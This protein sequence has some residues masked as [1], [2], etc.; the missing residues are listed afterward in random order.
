MTW[1][2]IGASGQF[3]TINTGGG[4]AHVDYEIARGDASG[5]IDSLLV[6]GLQGRPVSPL[7]P[8]SGNV[9][10]WEGINWKPTNVAALITGILPHDLLS[11][12]HSDSIP[13]SPVAGDIISATSG[14]PSLWGRFPIGAPN[15]SLS[16]NDLNQLEW[17]DPN[18]VPPLIVTSGTTVSLADEN[19]R[20]VIVKTI[21]SPTTVNLPTGPILGQE[22]MIKDG[23]GD[24]G[25]P[26]FNVIDIVPASGTTIDGFGTVRIRT[27]Y[28]AY[29]L[30]WNGT[31]WN[32]I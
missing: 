23:K 20:V 1:G 31:E 29:T 10:T 4:I 9:L 13:A 22:V 30:M 21:G 26:L 8:D 16:V 32:I 7:A 15:Q 24:A 19:R 17:R 6:I 3:G 27:K 18:V 2:G 28:Q 5:L 25:N 12:T 11:L 14:A